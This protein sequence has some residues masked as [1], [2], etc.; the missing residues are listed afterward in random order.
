MK[1]ESL[2]DILRMERHKRDLTQEKVCE[3]LGLKLDTLKRI[4][5]SKSV[6]GT[7][8]KKLLNYYQMKK[9]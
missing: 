1:H 5:N 7:T 9:E 3:E 6:R 2:G 8:I 4:E